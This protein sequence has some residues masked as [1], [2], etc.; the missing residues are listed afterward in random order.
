MITGPESDGD[1]PG[2]TKDPTPSQDDP[3]QD[4]PVDDSESSE[5]KVAP[6]IS[7]AKNLTLAEGKARAQAAK[8][9]SQK[10]S[11]EMAADAKKRAALGSP[12]EAPA[13]AKGYRSLFDFESEEAEEEGAVT[14]SQAIS[15]DLDEQQ[16]NLLNSK[17]FLHGEFAGSMETLQSVVKLPS[18][19]DM[20]SQSPL[21][22]V[23]VRVAERRKQW[24]E[25]QGFS[26]YWELVE[27]GV[28]ATLKYLEEEQVT[29]VT[30][31]RLKA[32]WNE[33]EQEAVDEIV[34]LIHQGTDVKS[35]DGGAALCYAAKLDLNNVFSLLL[36]QSADVATSDEDGM[37][38]LHYAARYGHLEVVSLLLQ[39]GADVAATEEYGKTALHY[40]ASN[41]YTEVVSLLLQHGADVAA[42]EEDGKTALHYAARNGKTEEIGSGDVDM[43][44]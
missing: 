39:H 36:E 21:L 24:L 17:T 8:T 23:V 3:S 19:K 43:S 15:Y 44:V 16:E 14:E 11:E 18:A 32:V 4:A 25:K 7:P 31:E 22:A 40:A 35:S 5:A 20:E 34:A 33:T 6:T 12:T 13:I 1:S 41:G 10:R 26:E 28:Q 2:S 30:G 42:T 27:K 38:A 37:T 9:A 29:I